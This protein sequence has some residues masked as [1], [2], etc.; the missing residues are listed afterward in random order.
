MTEPTI[1]DGGVP[2]PECG[3]PMTLAPGIDW[4]CNAT[5][6][7][8]Y[9][10]FRRR[11]AHNLNAVAEVEKAAKEVTITLTISARE[12]GG[13]R[14]RGRGPHEDVY[15]AGKTDF[16]FSDLGVVLRKILA[17][18]HGITWLDEKP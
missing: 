9:Q 3:K 14:I 13:I 7:C 2:C 18:N 1:G 11:F 5:P 12:H 17:D 8:E 10:K 15:L 16:V 4:F 6:G